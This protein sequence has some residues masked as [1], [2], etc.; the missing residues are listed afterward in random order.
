MLPT[1]FSNKGRSISPLPAPGKRGDPARVPLH[2]QLLSTTARIPMRVQDTPACAWHRHCHCRCLPI[3]PCAPRED[4]GSVQDRSGVPGESRSPDASPTCPGRPVQKLRLDRR[5]WCSVPRS[6]APPVRPPEIFSRCR[7]LPL[8]RLAGKMASRRVR[9]HQLV[10]GRAGER[11]RSEGAKHGMVSAADPRPITRLVYWPL[12]LKSEL[13]LRICCC[14]KH[15]RLFALRLDIKKCLYKC[16]C[17][18]I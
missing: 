16:C 17:H 14:K 3:P 6:P 8:R 4:G 11:S 2:L 10:P 12:T 9:P 13:P 5:V 18:L 7:S 15:N 1:S